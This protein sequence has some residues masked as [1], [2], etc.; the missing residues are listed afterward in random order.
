[1]KKTE[2]ILQDLASK[3][4]QGA[5]STNKLPT[6]RD[7]AS[8]YQV[9][10]YTVQNA[11]KKLNA[12]GVIQAKHG[13][14]I[15]V[16]PDALNN[17]LVFNAL[18]R[19]PYSEIQNQMIYLKQRPLTANELQNFDIRNDDSQPQLAWEFLRRR[20]SHYKVTELER[21]VMPV[22]LFPHLDRAAVEGSIQQF[23]QSTGHRISHY[24]TTYQTR[25][26]TREEAQHLTTK[27]QPAMII[28]NRCIWENSQVYALSENVAINYAVTYITPFNQQSLAYRMSR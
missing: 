21:T 22:R 15:Y 24:I 13:S 1:M 12:M 3:I 27:R 28:S 23:V 10:R 14:G 5:F 20:L 4:Y 16:A 18:T 2:F 19:M 11:L 6:E 25:L 8:Y 17:P 7:L 9:S 26:L